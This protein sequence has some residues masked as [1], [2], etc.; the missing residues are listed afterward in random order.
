MYGLCPSSIKPIRPRSA[1]VK[2]QSL[3]TT[4]NYHDN[5]EQLESCTLVQCFTHQAV[6]PRPLSHTSTDCWDINTSTTD[7]WAGSLMLL[8]LRRRGAIHFLSP[9]HTGAPM[10]GSRACE[11]RGR[12]VVKTSGRAALEEVIKHQLPVSL[13]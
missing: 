3:E 4:C 9:T 5:R 13:A 11:R 7:T 8:S 2:E 6:Q 10:C 1:I 12:P